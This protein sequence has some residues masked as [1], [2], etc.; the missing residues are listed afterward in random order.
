MLSQFLVYREWIG[1]I[2]GLLSTAA[3]L[4]QVVKTLRERNA[5]DISLGMYVLFC[6]GVSLWVVYG[7]MISSWPIV[8][9]NLITL[10]L[11]GTILI[12]ELSC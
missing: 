9:C 5:R 2:A 10:I 4:P 7:F 6:S 8:I 12:L 1:S 11:S 3:F